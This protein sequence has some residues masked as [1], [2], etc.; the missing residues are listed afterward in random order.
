MAARAALDDT[1]RTE[2]DGKLLLSEK[3]IRNITLTIDE[4]VAAMGGVEYV[5]PETVTE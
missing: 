5:E 4:K 1:L 3:D 2:I